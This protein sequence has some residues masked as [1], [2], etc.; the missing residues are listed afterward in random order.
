M[1][2]MLC[3]QL[4]PT[5]IDIDAAKKGSLGQ[6]TGAAASSGGKG[7]S[8]GGS[9]VACGYTSSMNAKTSSSGGVVE[10][11]SLP[12][13]ALEVSY[14]PGLGTINIMGATPH[15]FSLIEDFIKKMTEKNRRLTLKFQS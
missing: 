9:T 12:L 15:Q 8:I 13:L 2:E 11:D 4:L 10:F 7:L 5:I 3:T 6:V 1:A 14:S